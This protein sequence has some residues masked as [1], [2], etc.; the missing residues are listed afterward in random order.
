M[1]CPPLRRPPGAMV[2]TLRLGGAGRYA[3]VISQIDRSA[4]SVW[5][6]GGGAWNPNWE[7]RGIPTGATVSVDPGS[8][9]VS[10]SD[11]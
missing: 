6:V 5:A 11:G 8:G 7:E 4:V 2:V 9:T 3:M 10:T 1:R